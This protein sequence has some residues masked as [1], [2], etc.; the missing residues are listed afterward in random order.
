M[1]FDAS[2]A[3]EQDNTIFTYVLK[4]SG[5]EIGTL[6]SYSKEKFDF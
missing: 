6:S 3:K 4:L 5:T 2:S 1:K